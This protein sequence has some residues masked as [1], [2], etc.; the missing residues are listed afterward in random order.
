MAHPLLPTGNERANETVAGLCQSEPKVNN[1]DVITV[2]SPLDAPWRP[3][4]PNGSNAIRSNT[5]NARA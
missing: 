1:K 2:H 4:G 3:D 5:V